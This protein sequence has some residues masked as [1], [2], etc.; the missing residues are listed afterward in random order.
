MAY[1]AEK[2]QKA[3]DVVDKFCRQWHMDINIKKSEVMVVPGGRTPPPTVKFTCRETELKEVSQYK[4]LGIQ[5][6]SKLDWNA[7]ITYALDK[8][9]K[10]THSMSKLLTNSRISSRAKFLVWKAYVRP[11]LDYGN[12]VWVATQEQIKK[13]ESMQTK[14][15][16]QGLK[17][18][19]KTKV[20]AVRVLMGCSSL[21]NRHK[22]S[23]LNYFFKVQAMGKGRLV[24]HILEP[25]GDYTKKTTWMEGMLK[26]IRADPHLN[27]G[28]KKIREAQYGGTLPAIEVLS[29][30]SETRRKCDTRSYG[31]SAPK[32][33]CN[34]KN[35]PTSPPWPT[36]PEAHSG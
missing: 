11:L 21:A 13:M 20:E 5:F 16:V 25:A 36:I 3:I 26:M 23:N 28:L 10:R 31:N 30:R 14:A 27:E 35:S 29:T 22:R 6:T 34:A 9:E 19:S 17:L 1:S 15:G 32:S 24:R 18:S 8:A 4:Y 12:E 7:H 33:G 2:L